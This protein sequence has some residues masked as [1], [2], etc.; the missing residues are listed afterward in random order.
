MNIRSISPDPA[1]GSS[2]MARFLLVVGS[3]LLTLAFCEVA[4]RALDLGPELAPVSA[5]IFRLSP[6]PVLKYDL[7]PGSHHGGVHVNNDGMRDRDFPLQKPP[8]TFRIAVIGDS[9]TYGF[10]VGNRQTYAK[11]LERLLRTYL[12]GGTRF[13]VLNFG[14]AGYSVPEVVES[15]RVKALR[16]DP[17]LV[18]YG[19]CLNDPEI[20]NP[21][22]RLLRAQ[23]ERPQQ[24]YLRR[25]ADGRLRLYALARY[26]LDSLRSE[27]AAAVGELG[28]L[29]EFDEEAI[30]DADP[31]Y[32]AF[33]SGARRYERYIARLHDSGP[34][35]E[36]VATGLDDLGAMSRKTGVPIVV[37]VFPLMQRLEP[38]TLEPVHAKLA[39][40]IEERGLEAFDLTPVFVAASADPRWRNSFKRDKVHPRSTGHGIAAVALFEWLVDHALVPGAA[41]ADRERLLRNEAPAALVRAALAP[42]SRRGS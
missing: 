21:F 1:S 31:G 14:V 32:V 29:T 25:L 4:V 17:D 8:R 41:E 3:T 6:N 11:M 13:E 28:A 12:K 36:A 37:A 10:N 16:Y 33:H 23:L 15:L 42:P 7:Q 26:V 40:E 34:T 27:P 30:W 20:Y 38:Y 2:R 19:Y 9:I 35:W 18:I 39:K 24:G 22:A 5:E